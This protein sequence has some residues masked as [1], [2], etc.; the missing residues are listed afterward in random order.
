MD[1]S[2]DSNSTP[3]LSPLQPQILSD[4]DGDTELKSLS[5]EPGTPRHQILPL[6]LPKPYTKPTLMRVKSVQAPESPTTTKS[7]TFDEGK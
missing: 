4:S 2:T 3:S 6:F 7:P 1:S 5:P